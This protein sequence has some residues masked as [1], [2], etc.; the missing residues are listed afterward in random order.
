MN[1]LFVARALL[2]KYGFAL[3]HFQLIHYYLFLAVSAQ[4]Q[5][6]SSEEYSNP[7]TRMMLNTYA[8]M[9]FP[10]FPASPIAFAACKRGIV[11]QHNGR[12]VPNDGAGANR[13]RIQLR[14][15]KRADML[16]T[17]L[18]QLLRNFSLL[19]PGIGGIRAFTHFPG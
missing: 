10:P 6:K 1:V 17:Y 4:K 14:H 7:Q 18:K 11:I 8:L 3:Y 5:K 9:I 15:K 2:C 13:R 19:P 16:T 12:N